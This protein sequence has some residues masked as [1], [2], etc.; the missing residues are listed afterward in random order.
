MK[1]ISFILSVVVV[2]ALGAFAAA[3]GGDD[4]NGSGNGN[5]GGNNQGGSA[6]K[7]ATKEYNNPVV[8]YSVP[9][10][11]AIRAQDG[12][13]YLYGTE[14]TRNIPVFK[15]KDMV[16][17]ERQ[18]ATC[19]TDYNRPDFEPGNPDAT[20]SA[21]LWAPEIRYIKNKYV[22]FYSLA[23]WGNGWVSTI[24]YAVADKPEGPFSPKGWVFNSRQM[25][26]D[27]GI[28][29]FYWEEDGKPYMVWG[30]FNGIYIVE[31]DVTDD[32]VITPKK[33]TMVR[34][35]GNAYEGSNLWKR[36]GY[37]YLICSTGSCCEGANS[38][39]I[40]VVGRS[41]SLFGPYV[42]K[43]GG[44]ML[45]NQHELIV[46][47]DSRWAGTGHNSI[48]LED[49]DKNVWMLYH[50]YAKGDPGRGRQVLLDKIQ[51]DADGWPSV[52]FQTP[53]NF[54]DVPVIK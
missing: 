11:T 48:W 33:D 50:A 25:S 27:N 2:L 4:D 12:Y 42:N 16:N 9:D 54:A 28:D 7:P 23:E 13:F 1:R 18:P 15:S 24:G 46:K 47:G 26:V 8:P 6:D 44:R 45:D 3:C 36:D 43:S 32:L 34:I 37:Y 17:W 21:A 14:D 52:A 20:R 10:P 29:Q 41:K 35:A 30:S 38:T 40:T 51:W 53:S 39:Y 22:L 19:F 5:Q 31:L 49:D